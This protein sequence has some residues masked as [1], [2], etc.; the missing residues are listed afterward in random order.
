MTELG[1]VK[2]MSE[3]ERRVALVPEHISGLIEAGLSVVVEEGAG[4]DSGFSDQEYRDKG[5][6]VEPRGDVLARA[7]VLLT[8]RTAAAVPAEQWRTYSGLKEGTTIIGFANPYEKHPAFGELADKGSSLLAMELMPRITRAQSMDALSA[9]ANLGGYKAVL[10]AADHLPRIFPMMM[11]AAG[12]ILPAQVFILGVGVAGLQ[13]I[14]TA[15]RLGGV[16]SAYDIRPEVKDQVH[17]LGAKFLEVELEDSELQ[18]EGGYAKEMDE[19]FY[20]RQRE[21]MNKVVS[22]SNV[23]ITTAA[24]PGKKAPILVTAEMVQQM[25]PGSVIV[26]IAAE[27]GGNCELTQAGE[28]VQEHGVTIIGPTDIPSRLSY[29]SSRLYS[30]NITSFLLHLL[31]EGTLELDREDEITDKTLVLD[32]GKPASDD[33]RS[34]LDL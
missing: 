13:A 34:R 21:M 18:T 2:E 7:E 11:T 19:E 3:G 12:T 23:I 5:A 22:E 31:R 30:K 28:T 33:L 15:K 17:S 20:R 8:V 1:V 10:L 27:R 16:V 26:D 4:E 9:M 29:N 24:V 32:H 25:K 6:E 14:A